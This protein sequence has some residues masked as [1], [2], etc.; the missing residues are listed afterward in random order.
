MRA[1][2]GAILPLHEAK[3]ERARTRTPEFYVM[4]YGAGKHAR[5]AD[6]LRDI[7]GFKVFAF[8]KFKS[9]G[10]SGWEMGS[11]V[12]TLPRRKRFDFVFSAYMLNV[13]TEDIQ[14]DAILPE[15][16]SLGSRVAHIV[17]D[18]LEE[19]VR[20]WLLNPDHITTEWFLNE[21]ADDA[22]IEEYEETGG[23]ISSE[24]MENFL[25]F[26]FETSR[27]FQRKVDLSHMGYDLNGSLSQPRSWKTWTKGI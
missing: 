16:E 17:R 4:D 12:S 10:G 11:V 19:S 13:V 21:F 25:C 18:D 9:T 26:G 20:K 7:E 14:D 2:M 27:G 23:R 5:H 6:F 8:D 1:L 3:Q 24:T 22:E 15:M